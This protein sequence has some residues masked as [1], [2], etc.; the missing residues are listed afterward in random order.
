MTREAEIGVEW[1]ATSQELPAA[2]R[3]WKRLG[4]D[5]ALPEGNAKYPSCH[6]GFGLMK[7]TLDFWPLEL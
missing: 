1:W 4:I 6:L 5:F 3:S 7:L 2:T